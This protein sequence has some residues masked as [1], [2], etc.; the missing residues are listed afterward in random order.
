[1]LARRHDRIGGR[2]EGLGFFRSHRAIG[3]KPVELL[4]LS[5]VNLGSR[6]D[7]EVRS[8]LG[9]EDVNLVNDRPRFEDLTRDL[10][11][12]SPLPRASYG[13]AQRGAA[14]LYGDDEADIDLPQSPLQ[15]ASDLSV[16]ADNALFLSP[17]HQ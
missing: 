9:W 2:E 13:A 10:E 12:R 14:A 4:D 5:R 8:C 11:R 15:G 17:F 16:S 6:R 3:H 1:V 7:P